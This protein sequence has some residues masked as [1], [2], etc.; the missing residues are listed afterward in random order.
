MSRGA[1]KPRGNSLAARVIAF[2]QANPDEELYP[3]DIAAKW[4]VSGKN[5]FNQLKPALN[6]GFVTR[7]PDEAGEH[8]YTAGPHLHEVPAAKP[9][10]APAPQAISATLE[11]APDRIVVEIHLHIH[12]AEA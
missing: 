3:S 2:F 6:A 4:G 7:T 1:Y 5:V 9:A 8:Y 11:S 12:T 10:H